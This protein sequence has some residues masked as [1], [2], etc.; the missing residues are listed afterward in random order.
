AEVATLVS[1]TQHVSALMEASSIPGV[2]E[3]IRQCLTAAQTGVDVPRIQVRPTAVAL[4]PGKSET[5]GV[6]GTTPPVLQELPS[7]APFTTTTTV[8]EGTS[9]VTIKADDPAPAGEYVLSV[10]APIAN[11]DTV[12]RTVRVIVTAVAPKPTSP[13]ADVNKL[14]SDKGW[15]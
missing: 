15:T 10:T 12:E 7:S 4:P 5:V 1:E 3:G 8:A 6:I 14:L 9:S 11:N 2:A 13:V